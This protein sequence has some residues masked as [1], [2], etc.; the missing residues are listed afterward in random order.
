V[1]TWKKFEEVLAR[2]R[3]TEE[4]ERSRACLWGT[5]LWLWGPGGI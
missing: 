4:G 3:L 1:K 2:G 5:K